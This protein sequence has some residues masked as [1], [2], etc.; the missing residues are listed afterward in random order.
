MKAKH[1]AAKKWHDLLKKKADALTMRFRAIL[2]EILASKELMGKE[3][4]EAHFSLASAKY[5]AGE[6][7]NAVMEN[8][9][10]A[11]YR[12][13]IDEDNV[14]GVILPNFKRYHDNINIPAEL[15]GLGRG[16]TQI[17]DSRQ[18]YIKALDSLIHLASLQTA[19]VTLDEVIKITNRRV[20]AI[21]YVVIPKIEN[22]ISYIVTELDERDREEFYRLKMIQKKK[23]IVK[24]RVDFDRAEFNLEN[25][26][27]HS[28]PNLLTPDLDD[29]VLN[30]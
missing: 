10:E 6:F 21:E 22:T 8:V 1:K 30:Y 7:S 17:R 15:H 29:D 27:S 11:T 25:E 28:V 13:K 16:G 23:E 24:K 14:A 9:T 26:E 4:R 18:I 3:M 2:R 12:I 19:F 5:H 20:N